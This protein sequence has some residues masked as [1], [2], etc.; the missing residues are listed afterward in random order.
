MQRNRSGEFL[1]YWDRLCGPRAAPERSEIAPSAIASQLADT[2]ML[3]TDAGCESQFRLAGTRICSIHGRELKHMP[4]A[5][6][7]HP[8]DRS[9][10]SRLVKSCMM[11]KTSMRL[12]IEGTTARGRKALF[13]LTLLPLASE[14]N[15][16]YL[17]GTIIALGRSFWLESDPIV[18]NRIQTVAPL[19]P[20]KAM[21]ERHEIPASSNAA[22]TRTFNSR[23]IISRKVGHLH[24]LNGGKSIDT[25]SN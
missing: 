6:L 4:F 25:D 5:M 1:A 16:H 18:E 14:A 11:D 7:W 20:R 12:D 21:R 22:E 15:V 23:T 9:S 13:E 19:D 17:I 10:I 3:Q 2:F 24:V 8:K